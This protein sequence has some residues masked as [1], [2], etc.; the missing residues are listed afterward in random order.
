MRQI[1]MLVTA[2]SGGDEYDEATS[3]EVETALAEAFAEQ[4]YCTFDDPDEQAAFDARVPE[5]VAKRDMDQAVGADRRAGS[6]DK[7]GA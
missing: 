7:G 5:A 6:P 3:Y 2:S 4:G 1:T